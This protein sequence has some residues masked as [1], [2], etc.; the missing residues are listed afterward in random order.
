MGGRLPTAPAAQ[1]SPY[2]RRGTH[3]EGQVSPQIHISTRVR[4]V[5]QRHELRGDRAQEQ[6]WASVQ[7][8]V[9]RRPRTLTWSSPSWGAM[10]LVSPLAPFSRSEE[11]CLARLREN[12]CTGVWEAARAS[13]ELHAGQTGLHLRA[14]T[15][16]HFLP[17]MKSRAW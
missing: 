12:Q 4:E 11:S 17:E 8:A 14:Q 16:T 9:V 1:C 6:R 7:G 3:T 10:E 2:R 15:S 13:P 5:I